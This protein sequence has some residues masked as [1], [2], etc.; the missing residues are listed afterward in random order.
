MGN[1]LRTL[2]AD[3][4]K[5]KHTPFRLAHM[6]IPCIMAAVFLLYY[7]VTPWNA[8][9]KVQAYFQMMGLGYPFLIGTF[10]AIIAE[11]EAYAGAYQMILA[12]TDRRIAFLSKLL[13]LVLSGTCSVLLAS[14]LFGTGYDIVMKRH[15]MRYSF[16]L[17]AA[18]MM[19]GGSVFLYVWHLAWALRFNKGVSV[20]LGIA[21]S[22]VAVLCMTG[23]GDVIWIYLPPAWAS[24]F[25]CTVM[26]A[27]VSEGAPSVLAGSDSADYRQIAG[28]G[29][30]GHFGRGVW[31]CAAVTAVACVLY[32]IWGSRWDGTKGEE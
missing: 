13:L 26:P 20:G 25:V 21:E 1:L 11:Q 10:C 28:S 27:Y 31:I 22:L 15:V 5:T 6:V 32:V 2:K 30:W 29:L 4:L 9:S 3:Y 23:L 14:M 8:Y 18:F 7:A 17:T 12:V 16:Y 19:A 24:R